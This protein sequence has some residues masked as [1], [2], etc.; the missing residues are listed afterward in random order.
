[1]S[2]VSSYNHTVY[3]ELNVE[4]SFE[5]WYK[6]PI[7]NITLFVYLFCNGIYISLNEI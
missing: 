6:G 4:T 7:K 3:T 1:M 2:F 5:F